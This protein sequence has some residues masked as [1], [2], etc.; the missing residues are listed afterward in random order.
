MM[1]AGADLHGDKLDYMICGE[2]ELH[3]IILKPTCS[4]EQYKQSL[5]RIT[6]SNKMKFTLLYRIGTA[7]KDWAE[8]KGNPVI[9]GIG[10]RI[11]G[12]RS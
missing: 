1:M 7:L 11:R 10:Y 2:D 9:Q 4:P 3:T 5:G 6:R 8:R 12:F